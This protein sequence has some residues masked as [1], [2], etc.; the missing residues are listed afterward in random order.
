MCPGKGLGTHAVCEDVGLADDPRNKQSHA[1]NALAM[2]MLP[3]RCDIMI[4]TA[5][6]FTQQHHRFLIAGTAIGLHPINGGEAGGQDAALDT[7]QK[8]SSATNSKASTAF[9]MP[10]QRWGSLVRGFLIQKQSSQISMYISHLYFLRWLVYHS[11]LESYGSC[12]SRRS[13]Q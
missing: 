8:R 12:H 5:N 3:Y 4:H 13:W 7:S 6:E 10:S 11:W 1:V 2:C 9:A